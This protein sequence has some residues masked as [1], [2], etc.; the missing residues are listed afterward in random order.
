MCTSFSFEQLD[1]LH[2]IAHRP[3][4]TFDDIS[5]YDMAFSAVASAFTALN[6]RLLTLKTKVMTS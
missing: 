1:A 2:H 5:G 6:A 3:P 4:S